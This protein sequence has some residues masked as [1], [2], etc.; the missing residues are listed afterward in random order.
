MNATMSLVGICG[1]A[2]RE[3]KD[4]SLC[5]MGRGKSVRGSQQDSL[6]TDIPG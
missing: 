3:G 6:G 2:G 4:R 1:S 5:P